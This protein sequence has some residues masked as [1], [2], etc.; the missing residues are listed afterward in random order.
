M[1]TKTRVNLKAAGKGET[2]GTS[3]R[4]FLKICVLAATSVGLSSSA[5]K[6]M[7]AA[8]AGGVKPSIIW[9]HFQEC[10]GCTESLLRTSHPDV[11]ELILDLV[12]LDYHETLFAAS[13]TQIEDALDKAIADNAGKYVL[14]VE[15]AIPT[16]ENG[17]YCQVGGRTAIDSLKRCADKAGAIVAIGSCASWG[18]VP[19][20]DPQPDRRN[21]RAQDFGRQDR[22]YHPRLPAQPL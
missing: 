11:A 12:S 20:A 22:G 1:K 14:V 7:A 5:G 10:T 18:G 4:D 17:I 13:G 9:L 6:A 15:G 21:R 16:K 19:S 2:S 8:V 3:R